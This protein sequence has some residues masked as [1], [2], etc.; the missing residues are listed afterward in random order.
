[1]LLLL[2]Q[3][4]AI[5]IDSIAAVETDGTAAVN[6]DSAAAAGAAA[7][8][9]DAAHLSTQF[10]SVHNTREMNAMLY[11]I[12][13]EDKRLLVA[14]HCIHHFLY[15]SYALHVGWVVFLPPWLCR[16]KSAGTD[17]QSVVKAISLQAILT[18]SAHALTTWL[19]NRGMHGSRGNSD[20]YS[21]AQRCAVD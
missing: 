18:S 17:L 5:M 10:Q 8:A 7:A 19:R 3:T 16:G 4:A 2:I 21:Q 20:I 6:T 12:D 13:C 9:A 1:M 14:Y 15:R 11:S